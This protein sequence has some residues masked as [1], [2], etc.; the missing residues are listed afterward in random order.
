MQ[1]SVIIVNYNVK[2]FL[3]QCLNSVLASSF[4]SQI[5]IIVLDND[6]SDGSLSYLE[7]K[8]PQVKFIATGKNLGF[9]KANNIG[10]A[11]AKG[12]YL[13]LLNPD[14]VVGE[15]VFE[16]VFRFMEENPQA[17]AIGVRMLD[18]NGNFLPESKRSF[19]S[20]WVSFCKI[21]GLNKLFPHSPRF[22]SYDLRY[23]SHTEIH[24]VEV[25]AGAFMFMRKE[26]LMKS[27]F[28]DEQFF[29]YGEDIDLS[30]RIQQAGYKNFYLPEK[31]IHYKGESAHDTDFRYIKVFYSA[32]YLFYKKHFGNKSRL[33]SFFIKTGIV[34]SGAFALVKRFLSKLLKSSK[35]QQ[36]EIVLDTATYS[37]EEIIDQLANKTHRGKRIYIYNPTSGYKISS[38]TIKAVTNPSN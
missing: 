31:I 17:G 14:T 12:K 5:E 27:G 11:Q 18:G 23:L 10:M 22:A 28:L 33:Y 21:V 29:M 20:P 1:L 38:N 9:A 25:L 34:F 30:Y 8:F 32:M 4:I 13:L 35:Q 7:P 19:P 3:E 26:A 15:Q 24:E 36:E 37:Y 2:H 6:S 16:N